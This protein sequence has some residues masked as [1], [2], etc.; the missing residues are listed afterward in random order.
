MATYFAD[1]WQ[2]N[3]TMNSWSQKTNFPGNPRSAAVGFAIGNYGYIGSG[4]DNTNTYADIYK[5]DPSDS[6]WTQMANLPYSL[7]NAT[8]F[9]L[10]N[11]AYV[12][13][14]SISFPTINPINHFWEYFPVA[15]NWISIANMS[16]IYRVKPAAFSIGQTGYCGTGV[17]DSNISMDTVDFWAYTP[18]DEGIENVSQ[19]SIEINIYPNPSQGQMTINFSSLDNSS[20]LIHVL[21]IDG[22]IICNSNLKT[23][24]GANYFNLDVSNLSKGI[25]FLELTSNKDTQIRKI[26][27]E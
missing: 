14:G 18:S 10:N 21:N 1:L 23:V 2:Y 4:D 16:P 25:Y 24:T 6:A 17:Y 26:V 27:L 3:T 11:K 15:D 12:G 19:K 8:V 7:C 9:V 5:Y 20:I 13:T 22:K